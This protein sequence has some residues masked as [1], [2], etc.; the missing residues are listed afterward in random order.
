[1][2]LSLQ[3][4]IEMRKL[5][6]GLIG[7]FCLIILD[8]GKVKATNINP[9]EF[10]SK[11]EKYRGKQITLKGHISTG[12]FASDEKSLQDYKGKTFELYV[13]GTEDDIKIFIPEH[14]SNIPKAAYLDK[15]VVTFICKDGELQHGNVAVSIKLFH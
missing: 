3:E 13:Y 2:Y 14:F 12:I 5:F 8:A 6:V 11:T 1:M 7:F 4:F 10:V 15:V 9:A